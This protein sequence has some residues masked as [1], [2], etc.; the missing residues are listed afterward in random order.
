M[1]KRSRL[2]FS[3]AVVSLGLALYHGRGV[4]QDCSRGKELKELPPLRK[5][6]LGPRTLWSTS[7][8]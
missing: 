8:L 3:D 2:A 4:E 6:S 7:A 1:K 5:G